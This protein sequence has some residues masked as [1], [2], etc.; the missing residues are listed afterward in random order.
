MNRQ[1]SALTFVIMIGV[2]NFFADFTYEG[3]RSVIGPFMAQL[4]ATAATISIVSGVGEFFGYALRGLSGFVAD[5][6]RRYWTIASAGYAVNLL[7]VPALAL[8][9][10]WPV[11]A[12][13]IVAERTGR[14][15]RRPIVQSML[16]HA[17]AHLGGGRAFGMHEALDAAGATTG[18]LVIALALSKRTN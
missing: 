16:S 8:A 12:A 9:R 10:S 17:G 7:A 14:A 2:A 4:G 13:L 1:K 15:T 5:K 18:P 11:A 3:G 6:T